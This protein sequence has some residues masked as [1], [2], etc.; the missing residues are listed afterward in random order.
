M[1]IATKAQVLDRLAK[2]SDQT[3][4]GYAIRLFCCNAHLKTDAEVRQV[5]IDLRSQINDNPSVMKRCLG[6]QFRFIRTVAL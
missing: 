4:V 6:S 2:V 5:V 1:T 3:F